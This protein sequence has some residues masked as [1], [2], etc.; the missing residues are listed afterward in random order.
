MAGDTGL[1]ECL[2]AIK[3]DDAVELVRAL[4]DIPSPTGEERACA[5]FLHD[6]M[7][8]FD[9][10]VHLQELESGRANVIAALRGTGGGKTLMLNGHLDTSYYGEEAED[11]PVIGSFR[12]NDFARSFEIDGG[13]Y[14]LGSFNMKGGVAAA[15]LALR[16]MKKVGI[17]LP[18]TVLA[19]GVSGE[20]EK[21]QVRGA[22]RNYQG[23]RFR[24]GGYGTRSLIMH[25]DPIDYAIV[26]EPSDL[27]VV[28]AQ[29]GYMFVKIVVRGRSS[30]LSTAG[31]Q[32]SASGVNAINEAM[33]L[34]NALTPWAES[35]AE[36]HKYE[37]GLGVMTPQVCLGAIDSGT[38]FAPTHIPGVCHLYLNLRM[39]PAMTTSQVMDEINAMLQALAE[40]R[41]TFKY[42]VE[43][44]ASNAPSTQT[45]ADSHLVQ[46]AIEVMENAMGLPTRPFGKGEAD[47]SNDTNV[48]RRHGIPAIKCGP[49]TRFESNASEN[50]RVHGVHVYR[51]DIVAAARFYIR[52]AFALCGKPQ[53]G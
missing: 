8:T 37:T 10:D 50:M 21:A 22:V 23:P 33:A 35:Y 17:R 38:P 36:R 48:F 52:M 53:K 18:G 12:P 41:P 24:G 40:E 7:R 30:Y 13:I 9:I 2:D 44:Y 39:T 31:S 26:A 34:V 20:S 27:Y 29:A 19:S 28:N 6:H 49:K 47:P 46:T 51:D 32:G 25:C 5:E 16:A 14:G 1:Q 11:Y 4:V 3:A 42:E 15:F 43:V 45:P